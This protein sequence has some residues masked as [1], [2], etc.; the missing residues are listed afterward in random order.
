[1]KWRNRNKKIDWRWN[2]GLALIAAKKRSSQ[3]LEE[4]KIKQLS[5]GWRELSLMIM[6]GVVGGLLLAK[7][8]YLQLVLGDDNF[9]LAKNNSV[10]LERLR[11]P[12]GI[13]FDRNGQ[14]LTEN[15]KDER[16]GVNRK[17][18]FGSE[19]AHLVGYVSEVEKD[20]IGCYQGSCYQA[21]MLVGRFG[22]EKSFEA[23]LRGIDGGEIWE[24]D[25]K[26]RKLR[27][28]GEQQPKKGED[29]NL[30]VDERL[31]Q[32]A[33]SALEKKLSDKGKGSVVALDMQGKVLALVS[34]PSFDPNL[35]TISKNV[36]ELQ[37]IL[38]DEEN[39][40]FLD[41]AIGGKYPPG[42]IFK[43][44]TAYAGL[45]EGVIT[46]ETKIED[47][48]ELRVGKYRYGNWYWDKYGKKDGLLN[49]VGALKRSNDIFFYK[50]GE[51]VGIKKLDEW[52][53][54]FGL[55]ERTGIELAGEAKG[56]VPTPLWKER[57]VGEKWFLGN[58]YHLAIGQGDLL[59]TP[60]QVA[61]MG[62]AA[63]SGQLC[64]VSVLKDK[65]TNCSNLG[66]SS[67]NIELVREGMKEACA[68]GGTA[69]PLFNFDPWLIC[70]TGTAQHGGKDDKPHA[71]ILVGYPG[72]KPEMV[73]VVMLESAGEGSAEA[74]VVAKEILE[75]WKLV[76]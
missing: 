17:Y 10:K 15:V 64:Q 30:S 34:Y 67:N 53:K 1:M 58:T 25:V 19:L 33:F 48:G 29:I 38:N 72:E 63:I 21:G 18:P 40:Y 73:L 3:D 20:E 45:E 70:K 31:Q 61:R 59:V 56:L 8:V 44:V 35:F 13:L 42:S 75:E 55:G 16:Y 54:K 28:L 6:V 68:P 7:V 47:V 27:K 26:G 23:K 32:I 57:Y 62:V 46:E 4:Q 11:A 37:R 49:V 66:L 43:L 52:A 69:F 74:G 2:E 36:T 9:L 41:R 24:E 51:K 76:K 5:W 22:A 14:A 12:R 39:Q 50:V 60:I 71:W 65:P